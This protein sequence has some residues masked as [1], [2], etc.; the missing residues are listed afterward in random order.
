LL[1]EI[2][3]VN[4][5]FNGK[6]S[7]VPLF[8]LHACSSIPIFSRLISISSK[9]VRVSHFLFFP[10]S[11]IIII[12]IITF[13]FFQFSLISYGTFW[14]LVFASYR[15][16]IEARNWRRREEIGIVCFVCCVVYDCCWFTKVKDLARVFV[17][18]L[19]L[20]VV[21]SRRWALLGSSSVLLLVMELLV[22]LVCLFHTPAI[23]FPL[24]VSFPLF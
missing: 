21:K 13:F 18:V 5:R 4:E 1:A 22:K 24:W 16:V 8:H 7:R 12:V 14:I 11:I 9:R 17:F 19:R 6:I 2:D 10:F 3:L 20:I 23:P 15:C